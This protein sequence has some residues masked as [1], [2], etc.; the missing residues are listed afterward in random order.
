MSYVYTRFMTAVM[1]AFYRLI[2]LTV[3][4]KESPMDTIRAYHKSGRKVIFGIWHEYSVVGIYWYRHK[5]G[6]A[7]VSSA[8]NGEILSGIMR[9]FGFQDF[10]VTSHNT[11]ANGRG[12]LGFIRYLKE[13]HDGT[14][15]MDGPDGPARK[16]KPG[17]LHVG[18]KTGNLVLPCGAC[19]SHSIAV[20]G[21][22]DN[23]QIPLPFSRAHIVFGEPFEIPDDFR[24]REDE[25]LKELNKK[26]DEIAETARR[27]CK[28]HRN[29][30]KSV[31]NR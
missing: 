3:R 26:T 5:R 25:V 24:Q 14:I 30:K 23:F 2:G 20:R 28:T 7:L 13:G 16:A 19:F 31:S 18:A 21:R 27:L 9:H 15:A 10:R 12:V 4:V 1:I 8:R 29:R 17:I 6:S 22:W 11:R